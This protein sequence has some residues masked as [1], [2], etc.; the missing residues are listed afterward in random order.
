[1]GRQFLLELDEYEAANLQWLLQLVGGFGD[2]TNQG[3]LGDFAEANTGDWVGQ[4]YFKMQA[5]GGAQ[6]V[7]HPPNRTRADV[8]DAIRCYRRQAP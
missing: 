1:M 6:P 4:I 2:Q 8:V 3:P 7:T 5:L